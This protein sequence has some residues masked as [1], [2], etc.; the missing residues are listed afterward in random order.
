MSQLSEF[1]AY[2]EDKK[3]VAVQGLG[4]VGGAM[5]AALSNAQDRVKN[6]PLY[7][8]LGVDLSTPDGLSKIEAVNEGR[9]PIISSDPA[10]PLAFLKAKQQGNIFATTDMSVFGLAD[11]VVVDIPF[12]VKKTADGYDVK[13]DLFLESVSELAQHINPSAL[14]VVE[15]TVPPGMTENYLYDIF[16]KAFKERGVDDKEFAL[17]HS[18]ERVM[19]GANYLS[20]IT[21][22]FRVYA[23]VNDA[24]SERARIF[25]ESFINTTDFPLTR[26]HKPAASEMAKVLENSYRALNIAFI[27]EWTEFAQASEVNLFSVLEAI[28][29]RPTHHNIMSPGFGVGGYCLTKDALLA[30]WASK[31][32]HGIGLPLSCEGI[33][34]NDVMPLYTL[35]MLKKLYGDLTQ[36][37][38]TLLGVSYLNDVADTRY[39]PSEIFCNELEKEGAIV[40]LHDPYVADWHARSEK[41][42]NTLDD[43]KRLQHDVLIL[44]VRHKL[45]CD[46]NVDQIVSFFPSVNCIVDANNILSEEKATTLRNMG[47]KVLG[48]GKGHWLCQ[49]NPK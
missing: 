48:I 33:R 47:I 2:N 32:V 44:A 17:A 31:E 41:I 4:F 46:L 23:G 8:V 11:I 24:S 29:M 18:Y 19:P 42:S 7:A 35:Q 43:L 40:Q 6:K 3:I 21:E 9:P 27:Q 25:L 49:S 45:Y 15:T 5:L 30:D 34:I 20:S 37:H 14:V 28:R 13:L 10:M 22:Y 38:V 26:L 36:K 1:I 12:D 39:T 16:K